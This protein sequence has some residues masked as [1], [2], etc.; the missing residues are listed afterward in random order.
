M[1]LHA[2]AK[3]TPSS[4]LLL[5]RRIQDEGRSVTEAAEAAGVSERTARKW[6]ARLISTRRRS[7]RGRYQVS[8]TARWRQVP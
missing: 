8:A 3:L 7:P 6:L 5:C 1:K 2:N 4:R